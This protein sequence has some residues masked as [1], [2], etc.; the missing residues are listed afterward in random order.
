MA[1]VPKSP[2]RQLQA[3]AKAR[4]IPANQSAGILEALLG[5][6]S[7]GGEGFA[8][9]TPA[10]AMASVPAAA[11]GSPDPTPAGA[12]ADAAAFRRFQLNYLAV[13]LLTAFADW[14][15]GTHM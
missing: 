15:Q 8:T 12:G 3:Q 4:G 14:L 11:S 10:T 1:S 7:A 13:Y 5:E 2:Y 6:E 9:R